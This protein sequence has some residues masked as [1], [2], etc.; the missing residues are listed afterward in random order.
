MTSISATAAK[1]RLRGYLWKLERLNR[2][3]NDLLQAI[4]APTKEEIDAMLRRQAPMTLE[5]WLVGALRQSLFYLA[6]VEEILT[7]ALAK[8]KRELRKERESFSLDLM[9]FLR[10]EVED[11]RRPAGEGDAANGDKAP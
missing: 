4:P 6:E 8:T 5:A 10:Q 7:V 9:R 1:R 11:R 3:L 2:D